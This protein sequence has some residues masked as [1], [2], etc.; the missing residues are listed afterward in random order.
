M[1]ALLTVN[2]L[3]LAHRSIGQIRGLA[4][5]LDLQFRLDQILLKHPIHLRFHKINIL[6]QTSDAIMECY[7]KHFWILVQ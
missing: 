4:M 6:G 7:D 3:F 5:I 1:I 2:N